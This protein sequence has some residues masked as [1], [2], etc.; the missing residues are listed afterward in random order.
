ML[1]VLGSIPRPEKGT[2]EPTQLKRVQ[3]IEMEMRAVEAEQ[4]KL[5][6][7]FRMKHPSG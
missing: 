1:L 4:E 2:S 5:R 6:I 7:E 3:T